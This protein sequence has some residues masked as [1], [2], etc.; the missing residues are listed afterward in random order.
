MNLRTSK[1]VMLLVIPLVALV[2]FSQDCIAGIERTAKRWY[3]LDI[4]GGTSMAQGEYDGIAGIEFFESPGVPLKVEADIL[5]QDGSH[6]GIDYGM[7][8]ATTLFA[9]GFRYTDIRIHE[10][11]LI[12]GFE[13]YWPFL[14]S[15]VNLSQWDFDLYLH[16]YFADL[17]KSTAAPYLGLGTQIGATSLTAKGYDSENKMTF[18]L[19]VDFGADIKIASG[20]GGRSFVTLSSVNS[21]QFVGT[22]DRPKYLNIGVGLKYFF[23]P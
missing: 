20:A 12:P 1:Y 4:Y 19:S 10:P 18:A 23:R 13:P 6:F 21:Y 8:N 17:S 16:Q 5:Y 3:M 11:I 14:A 9:L 7:M 22:N 2:L 15:G